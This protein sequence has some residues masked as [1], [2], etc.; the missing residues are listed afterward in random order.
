[1]VVVEQGYGFVYGVEIFVTCDHFPLFDG[2]GTHLRDIYGEATS[3][4][5]SGVPL[6]DFFIKTG[7]IPIGR[8]VLAIIERLF[9]VR[10]YP[11]T[12]I[13]QLKPFCLLLLSRAHSTAALVQG[14]YLLRKLNILSQPDISEGYTQDYRAH[15]SCDNFRNMICRVYYLTFWALGCVNVFLT[16]I[17]GK[18]FTSH[19]L[20]EIGTHTLVKCRT[21]LITHLYFT[22]NGFGNFVF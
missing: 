11:A 22:L 20:A 16:V 9:S 10:T 19:W 2:L 21:L 18:S 12:F 4:G 6:V 7:L 1:T 8:G 5:V 13:L 3:D 14:L 15:E 17:V